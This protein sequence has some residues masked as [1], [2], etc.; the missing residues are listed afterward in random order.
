MTILDGTETKNLTLY[1]PVWPSIEVETPLW[2]EIAEEEGVQ[3]LLTIGKALTF[4]D[5]TEDNAINI[6]ISEPT[7][8][9]KQIYQ[10]LNNNLG[11]EEQENLTEETLV[12]DTHIIP[13]LKILKSVPVEIEPLNINP[14][15]APDEQECL[16]TLLKKHKEE[17]SWESTDIK[18]IPSNLCTHHIYI[19]SDS[20]PLCQPQ[21]RM[22]PNLRDIMKEEIQ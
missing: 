13:V 9:N 2:M 17:F 8:V 5:E 12:S 7:S 3:P 14:N 16:I 20:E 18:G 1:P 4:K 22:N 10:L 11:E 19:K 6:F 15:I 21:W